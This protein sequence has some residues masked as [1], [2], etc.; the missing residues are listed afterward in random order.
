MGVLARILVKIKG[1][2]HWLTEDK[3][4]LL[5][6]DAGEAFGPKSFTII[7]TPELQQRAIE[8][9]QPLSLEGARERGKEEL[10]GRTV[11]FQDGPPMVAQQDEQ[12]ILVNL[13]TGYYGPGHE[14]GD[15]PLI[16]GVAR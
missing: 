5:A 9:L 1:E 15:L 8:T 10:A 6:H 13:G 3:V 14:Q 7:D 2:E 11:V 16:L 4:R 12:L